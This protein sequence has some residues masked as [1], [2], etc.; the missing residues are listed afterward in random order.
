M[1][2][3]SEHESGVLRVRIAEAFELDGGAR[4]HAGEEQGWLIAALMPPTVP[5][6]Q[7]VVE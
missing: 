2:Q 6:F 4:Q 5:M 1:T 7:Q 3:Q